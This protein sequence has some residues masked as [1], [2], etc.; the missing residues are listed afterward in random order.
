ML[1]I[2]IIGI[3]LGGALLYAGRRQKAMQSE[4]AKTSVV[5]IS[6]LQAGTQAE[7]YGTARV[8]QP[9]VTPFSKRE[10]VY[11]QYKL[12]RQTETRGADGRTQTHWETIAQDRQSIPFWIEDASGKVAVNPDGADIDAQK[13]GE[14]FVQENDI[15]HLPIFT[16]VRASLGVSTRA[17]EQALFANTPVYA[18]GSVTQAQ[19][20]L[21]LSKENGKMFLSYKTE[22]Q[23]EKER[24]RNAMLWTVFSG[25]CIVAGIVFIVLS[26]TS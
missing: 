17:T 5:P 26:L 19:D 15:V 3:V 18:M 22:A 6:Q 4:M 2:G 14:Q 12:E 21:M 13:I 11:Y 10:C 7:V 25:I 24:G 16:S 20:T 8:A 9:L 1:I 23:V